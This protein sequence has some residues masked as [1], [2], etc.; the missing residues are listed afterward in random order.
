MMQAVAQEAICRREQD[1][2]HVCCGKPMD[3][4]SRSAKT[5][6]TVV[7]TVRPKRRYYHCLECG[8]RR[9][10]A[11]QWLGWKGRSG[12]VEGACKHVVGQ[13]FKRQST[14]WTKQGARA[15]LHLRLDRLNGRW[16]E[17]CEHLREQLRKAA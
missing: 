8:R 9:F 14:R 11:D 7:G 2:V 5:V 15:V 17:R 4:E 12:V 1:Q 6:V 3:N 10:P 13:R 16:E